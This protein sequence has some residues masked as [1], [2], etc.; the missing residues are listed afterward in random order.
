VDSFVYEFFT[1][2]DPK[3]AANTKVIRQSKEFGMP[4]VVVPTLAPLKQRKWLQD[5]FLQIHNDPKG[6]KALDVMGVDRFVV[7]D[8]DHY[9]P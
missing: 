5:I 2:R 1:K 9:H 3:V 7:P 6:R 4:P 8:P